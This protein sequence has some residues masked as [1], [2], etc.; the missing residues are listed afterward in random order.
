MQLVSFCP[1]VRASHISLAKVVCNLWWQLWKLSHQKILFFILLSP[2]YFLSYWECKLEEILPV[3][4]V[5]TSH[6]FDQEDSWTPYSEKVYFVLAICPPKFGLIAQW[7]KNLPAMQETQEIW[8]QSPSWKDTLEK[9]MATCSSI[10]AWRIP[11]TE[12]PDRLRSL[13]SQRV[14]YDWVIKR[15]RTSTINPQSE[16]NS[17]LNFLAVHNLSANIGS[18][19]QC[20]GHDMRQSFC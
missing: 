15:T 8:V 14:G 12:E 20:L 7:V 11:R 17:F 10:L 9:E 2:P 3:G 18:Q 13:K 5:G 19:N 4:E 16:E 1:L 6:K